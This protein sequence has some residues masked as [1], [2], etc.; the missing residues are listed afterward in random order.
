MRSGVDH[1]RVMF[2]PMIRAELMRVQF[3]NAV[4][5]GR[6]KVKSSVRDCGVN[7]AKHLICAANFSQLGLRV[8]E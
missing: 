2:D 3:I 6:V 5:I 1:R 4:I 8:L 7:G